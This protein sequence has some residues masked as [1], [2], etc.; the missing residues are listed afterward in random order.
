MKLRLSIAMIHAAAI[1]GMPIAIL[2]CEGDA[3]TPNAPPP[4]NGAGLQIVPGAVDLQPG[5]TKEL[6]AVVY[7]A[8]G[9]P[10][11]SSVVEWR[12]T[13][14][15]V[16]S[17]TASGLVTGVSVGNAGVIASSNG[18]AD[19]ADV[20]VIP[21]LPTGAFIDIHPEVTYQQMT[22]WEGTAQV[23]E[24]ECD[25]RAFAVYQPVVV[26]RLVNE[27]G[28][29]R[30]RL[31]IRSGN[32]NPQDF[33]TQYRNG[34]PR[35]EWVA[36]R[37]ESVNDNDNPL[38]ARTGGFQF[39]ELDHK[40]E[41]IV[42]PLRTLLAARGERLYVNLNYVDFGASAWEHSSDPQE[43][44]ELIHTAF[45]H[46]Q[47]RYGW[48]PDAV[49]ISLEPDNTPNW[50]P[51]AIGGA[52]VATG[53]RLKSAGFRPAFIAPSNT[54]MSSALGY[55]DGL[56]AMPRVLEY[57]TDVSYHR[58]SGVSA[59]TLAAIASRAKEHGLRTAM[60]E[61]I[62]SDYAD[63]HT[64]L[65]DGLNSAWQ[66]FTLA[67]C[68]G[69]DTGGNY[70]RIDQSNPVS[71]V[72]IMGSRTRYLRQYFSFIRQDALRIGAVSG[73]SRLDPL[74]FRNSN[75]KIAVVIRATGA[76]PVHVR[77]L[78][79]GTYGVR[80]TTSTDNFASL[81]DAVVDAAGSLQVA[82]PASGVMTIFAR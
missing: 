76:A 33:Y 10:V 70:Y 65:R 63:L 52:L 54:N 43:Y 48:V 2:A 34:G 13:T 82:M 59:G 71:P 41:V 1:V 3:R 40:V 36:H 32:E 49:E 35:A 50:T 68:G 20:R 57:L 8:T 42:Q 28:I 73:E 21:L 58:Y 77:G 64:D 51:Q 80:F 61:H 69:Q 55:L 26:D 46:L 18:F 60:L 22:G 72:V 56:I 31:E 67:F 78:P 44:A 5:S 39:S 45:L 37:Y 19:T 6:K 74:A 4:A 11:A 24:M 15:A 29:N 30:V 81:P 23:G 25:P 79:P 14:S 47:S 27:L 7:D 12:T 66:Q 17:V 16:V 75:G 62:G 9:K 53:D 38:V